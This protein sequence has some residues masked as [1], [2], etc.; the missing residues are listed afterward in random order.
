MKAMILASGRGERMRPLTDS[1]P[2][3]LLEA[4]GKSLIQYHIEALSA[5]GIRQVVINHAW[6]GEMIEARLGDGSTSGVEITYSAEGEIPLETGGGIKKA[7]PLLGQDPFIVVN[8]DV[9]TDF[10]FNS[11][12]RRPA[13]YAHII[14]VENP[15]HHPDG[16]FALHGNRVRAENGELY[17]YSGIGVLTPELFKDS[18]A[19]VFPLAPLLLRAMERRKISGEIYRGL[20]FD[21]GTPERLAFINNKLKNSK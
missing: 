14:L 21:V 15:P 7:L 16:D 18:P 12:P 6:L 20:W 9:W 13:G 2:K 19:G 10:D 17:T 5:A 4:G 8:G 11:L 3:P 1:V